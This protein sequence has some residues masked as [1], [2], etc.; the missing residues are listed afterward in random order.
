MPERKGRGKCIPVGGA[1]QIEVKGLC[2]PGGEGSPWR[3]GKGHSTGRGHAG[4]AG[5]W[6]DGKEAWVPRGRSNSARQW[7]KGVAASFGPI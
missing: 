7:G 2:L 5:E 6:A 1:M 3:R 4:E